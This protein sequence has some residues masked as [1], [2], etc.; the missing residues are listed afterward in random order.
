[1]VAAGAEWVRVDVSWAAV[2]RSPG[3]HDW[4]ATDRVVRAARDR[5][6]RILGVLAYSPAWAVAPGGDDK[7][8]PG[9]PGAFAAFAGEAAGRYGDRVPAWE[10]GN[11]PN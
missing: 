9:D 5:E 7:T 3:E 10:S 11:E 6:L 1:M 2:E 4:S 8:P